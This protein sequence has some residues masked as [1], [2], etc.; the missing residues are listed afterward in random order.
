M[1]RAALKNPDRRR[2]LRTQ[3]RHHLSGLVI[4]EVEES[5]RDY[6]REFSS[7]HPPTE[8]G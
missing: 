1:S 6:G 5:V 7:C 4:G 3:F 2:E 8:A